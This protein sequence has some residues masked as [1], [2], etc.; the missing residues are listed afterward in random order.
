M[1]PHERIIVALDVPDADRA[2]ALAR[3]LAG[4][5]GLVKVGHQMFT[6]FGPDLVRAL[7]GRGLDVFLDLKFHDI[8]NTVEKGVE[9]ACALGVRMVTI[10]LS[11][12]G[13]MI[14]R[15]VEAAGPSGILVLGVS[16]LT[17][18][19]LH[20]L[21]ETGVHASPAEQVLRLAELGV[22][23]R[24]RGI[25]ASAEEVRAIKE[26]YGAAL[27]AVI[28]GIRPAGSANGDQARV[29]TPGEAVAAGADYLVIGRP[30]L[31]AVDPAEAAARIAAEIA[32]TKQ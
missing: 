27:T 30:I 24:L 19:T 10:H 9:S 2:L 15:A 7:I 25:V 20:T 1:L 8:P 3:S 22:R 14:R 18:S 23:N 29:M 6:R 13:E 21:A 16:V 11:G 5:V 28:P 26:R 32:D 31:E 12:G 17:S 4:R